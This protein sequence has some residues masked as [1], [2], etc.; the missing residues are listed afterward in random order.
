MLDD[1]GTIRAPEISVTEIGVADKGIGTGAENLVDI[2]FG[3]WQPHE[4][5]N[6]S[7]GAALATLVDKVVRL[8]MRQPDGLE[9]LS[10]DL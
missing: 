6:Q 5:F 2:G 9:A 8:S 4:E 7:R 1:L 3:R 10:M